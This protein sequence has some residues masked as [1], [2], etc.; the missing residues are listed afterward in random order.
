M[1]L[2]FKPTRATPNHQIT[3]YTGQQCFKAKAAR[4]NTTAVHAHSY[5]ASC[6]RCT[7]VIQTICSCF[8]FRINIHH[9]HFHTPTNLHLN[10]NFNQDITYNIHDRLPT[11]TS[12]LQVPTSQHQLHKAYNLVSKKYIMIHINTKSEDVEE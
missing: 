7:V 4:E 10:Y 12:P 9:I 2:G 3:L 5:V 6:I 8:E 11:H 1:L